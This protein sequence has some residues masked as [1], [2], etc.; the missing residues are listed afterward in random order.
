M[1]WAFRSIKPSNSDDESVGDDPPVPPP[2]EQPLQQQETTTATLNHLQ[3]PTAAASPFEE[4]RP[5]FDLHK[6]TCLSKQLLHATV[7][8]VYDQ[9]TPCRFVRPKTSTVLLWKDRNEWKKL[10]TTDAD[11][12]TPSLFYTVVSSPLKIAKAILSVAASPLTMRRDDFHVDDLVAANVAIVNKELLDECLE[13]LTHTLDRVVQIDGKDKRSLLGLVLG[14]EE[15]HHSTTATFLT[16]IP[17]D[18]RAFLIDILVGRRVLVRHQRPGK[19][20]L[21]I[22]ATLPVDYS[23]TKF[24]LEERI[25]ALESKKKEYQEKVNAHRNLA[26]RAK[27]GGQKD[28]A[29]LE[30]RRAKLYQKE[31]E[32]M[33]GKLLNIEQTL[34]QLDTSVENVKTLHALEQSAKTLQEHT[35]DINRVDDVMLDLEEFQDALGDFDAALA[36]GQHGVQSFSDEELM[37]ELL[38]EMSLD[39]AKS[40]VDGVTTSTEVAPAANSAVPPSSA[41]ATAETSNDNGDVPMSS[42]ETPAS[43]STQSALLS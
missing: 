30:L 40:P 11:S 1:M 36:A 42:W 18:Q 23:A 17:P 2:E 15:K 24:E 26:L 16:S 7:Q 43:P 38:G 32:T 31:V 27:K 5:F 12:E 6:E 41:F 22:P 34:L 9:H 37:A 13:Y 29:L 25:E 35:V 21:L 14:Q 33:Y 19:S 3:S 8:Q 39:D 4:E 28:Q 20:D 10:M